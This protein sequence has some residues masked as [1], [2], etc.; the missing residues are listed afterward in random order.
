[1][2]KFIGLNEEKRVNL[3]EEVYD[4]FMNIISAKRKL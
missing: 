1:M 3:E 4:K 2:T